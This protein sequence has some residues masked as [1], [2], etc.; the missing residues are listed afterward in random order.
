MARFKNPANGYEETTG[1]GNFFGTL[2]LGF[3]Y[4]AAK[5]LWPHAVASLAGVIVLVALMGPVG[6]LL[7]AIMWIIYA[8]AAPSLMASHYKRKGWVEVPAGAA[9]YSDE[10]DRVVELAADKVC[11]DCAETVKGAAKK[12]RYCGHEF[13]QDRA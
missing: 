10:A 1:A 8:A 11:P 13:V 6:V 9:A 12:C 3:I 4:L 5:G 2:F 7:A